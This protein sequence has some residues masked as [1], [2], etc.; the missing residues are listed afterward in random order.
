MG[1]QFILVLQTV[2]NYSKKKKC[3]DQDAERRQGQEQGKESFFKS[4]SPISCWTY[5]PPT[6]ERK[7]CRTSWSRS[8]SYLAA[9]MEY[10]AAE[11]LELAGNAARDNKK[12]RII[13]RH[14]QLAIRNDEE[15]NK[16]LAGVTIAQGG[17]L[18]NIQAVLLPKKTEKSKTAA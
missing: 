10:L 2:N 7:L 6:S 4:R 13:P 14:L 11:V 8:S 17:V 9:V 3:L 1:S 5:S 15:L 16:L 12:T 18:P